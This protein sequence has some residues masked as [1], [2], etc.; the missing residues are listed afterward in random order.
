[1]QP[2]RSPANQSAWADHP[3]ATRAN[4]NVNDSAEIRNHLRA[5]TL[6]HR[7]PRMTREQAIAELKEI[8]PAKSSFCIHETYWHHPEREEGQ[9]S[10][11]Q[12]TVSVLVPAGKD[13]D[14]FTAW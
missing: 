5:G 10:E 4:A 6:D 13:E 7:R 3:H 8:M 14:G 9:Q 2:M 1:M 12:F 11:V